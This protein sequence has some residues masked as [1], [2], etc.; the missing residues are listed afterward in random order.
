MA[1]QR[2][3]DVIIYIDTNNVTAGASGA[4]WSA[5][6]QQ[7]GGNLARGIETADGTY[8]E[9]GSQPNV[10][11]QRGIAT[12]K[13][14]GVSCDGALDPTDTAWQELLDRWENMQDIH[15]QVEA[16]NVSGETKDGKAWITDLSYEFPEADVVTF[17]ADFQGDGQLFTSV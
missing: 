2:G 1:V 4:S 12:R 8:K 15:V 14:W 16:A 6:G 11:W 9:T 5:I 17:T 7:R 13:T 10:G 3:R